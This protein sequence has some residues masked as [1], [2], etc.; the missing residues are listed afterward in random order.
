MRNSVESLEE[1]LGTLDSRI[2]AGGGSPQLAFA[3]RLA[4]E[5]LVTNV[6]KYGYDDAVEHSIRVDFDF[7]PPASMSI[8][9]D[10]H[11]FDPV[12]DAPKPDLSG[13]A[14]QRPIGGLG[15]HMVRTMVST[16][17]YSRECDRNR[18]EL[19]FPD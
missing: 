5:D 8:E 14:A 18:L 13:D 19:T 7:G 11:A 3:A 16:I 12:R 15:L 1:A 6:I 10:G 2:E 9:D 4:M 17:E